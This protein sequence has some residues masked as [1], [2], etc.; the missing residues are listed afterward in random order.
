MSGFLLCPLCRST[1]KQPGSVSGCVLHD[2]TL[3]GSYI[4]GHSNLSYSKFIFIAV[5][6]LQFYLTDVSEV[7]SAAFLKTRFFV[8]NSYKIQAVTNILQGMKVTH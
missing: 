3:P 7:F 2:S 4:L 5:H 8:Y 1:S 6:S